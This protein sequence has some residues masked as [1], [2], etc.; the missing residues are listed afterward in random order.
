[1]SG[2]PTAFA[3]VDLFKKALDFVA[4]NPTSSSTDGN[5]ISYY[6]QLNEEW[7]GLIACLALDYA[8]IKVR[9]V[10]LTYS[11]N[12]PIEQ[13]ILLPMFHQVKTQFGI[14]QQNI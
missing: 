12:K 2:I 4:S 14:A 7:R 9:R 1:M 13:I 11:D 10:N 5:I 8:H 6:Y 3:R